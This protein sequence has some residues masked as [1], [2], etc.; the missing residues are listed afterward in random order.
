[1]GVSGEPARGSTAGAVG[2]AAGD[3]VADADATLG[4]SGT[5]LVTL[6]VLAPVFVVFMAALAGGSIRVRATPCAR[7]TV[8]CPSRKRPNRNVPSKASIATAATAR[9]R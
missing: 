5:E 4:T 1:V 2:D 7:G 8:P 6:G 3:A 9:V